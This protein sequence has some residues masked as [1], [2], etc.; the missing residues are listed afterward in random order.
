MRSSA[1]STPAGVAP[2]ARISSIDSRLAPPSV[3]TSSTISTRPL[4]GAPTIDAAFAVILGFLAVVAVRQIVPFFG[5]RDRRRRG[6]RDALVGR[7][8]QLV[9]RHAGGQV[10]L[11]VEPAQPAQAFAVVEQSRVEEVRSLAPGLGDELRQIEAR[12]VPG[13]SR[14]IPGGNRSSRTPCWTTLG[15]RTALGGRALA[16]AR[17]SP[18]P[19]FTVNSGLARRTHSIAMRIVTLNVNGIRSA[20]TQGSRALARRA[21]SRGTSSACRRSR[22]RRATC[23]RAARAAQV[24][25]GVS[26][27]PQRKGYS[28]VA[29]YAAPAGAGS[30]RLRQPRIR[31]RGPL[32][33]SRFRPASVISLYLAVGLELARTGRRP[34]SAS[35]HEFLPHLAAS[36]RERARGHPVRRLEHRAPADRPQEL[37]QQPEELRVPARGARL[38]DARVRRARLRRRVPQRQ[39]A[40]RS[41]TRGGRTA[42]RRGRRTS[43]G[44]STTRSRRRASPRRRG[45]RRSTRTGASP[46]TRR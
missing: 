25:C 37:A 4:S 35:S 45:R 19:H 21:S 18:A 17:S 33:R 27:R 2:C 32:P 31:R 12:R 42:A 30:H 1:I 44:A 22:R 46:I 43:A 28:G 26:I 34:S 11:G 5:Q 13:R 15:R 41:S 14:E 3:I 16:A 39:P 36:A 20:R 8:E 9:A 7:S 10:R 29:L 38:A 6:Q 23:P 24:A 40:S